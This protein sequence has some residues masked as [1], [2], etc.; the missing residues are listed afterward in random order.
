MDPIYR[1]PCQLG[2]R[3]GI[4]IL[5]HQGPAPPP[6]DGLSLRNLSRYRTKAADRSHPGSRPSRPVA[7]DFRADQTYPIGRMYL[8]P[9]LANLDT[10]GGRFLHVTLAITENNI[11]AT[12]ASP[13]A[14][15]RVEITARPRLHASSA[16]AICRHLIDVRPMPARVSPVHEMPA[17]MLDVNPA[18]LP[19]GVER[20]LRRE[21]TIMHRQQTETAVLIAARHNYHGRGDPPK[22]Q[23]GLTRDLPGSLLPHLCRHLQRRLRRKALQ[24]TL[25]A[26]D[27]SRLIGLRFS[28]LPG[29]LRST[30]RANLQFGPRREINPASGL[31]GP[32]RR[33]DPT[34]L[35]RTLLSLITSATIAMAAIGIRPVPGLHGTR[36]RR[37]GPLQDRRG[38]R[39]T[40][41][42]PRPGMHP[43]T[44]LAQ[45]KTTGDSTSKTLITVG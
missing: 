14:F 43:A 9:G 5:R 38:G 28:T 33:D 7:L 13:T 40:I 2:S 44:N 1:D 37:Q 41:E 20:K 10:T 15:G 35:R 29:L 21:G 17:A 19:I 25:S 23:A 30:T 11:N 27:S 24:S 3:R 42:R 32:S 8:A 22:A 12:R 26:H 31:R 39:R 6:A 36:K 18:A 34:D 45:I 4:P 16:L